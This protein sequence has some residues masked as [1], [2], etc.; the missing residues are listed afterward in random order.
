M[1]TIR[2]EAARKFAVAVVQRLR[3]AGFQ[4]LWAGG[5]VRDQ[6]LGHRPKDYDVATDARPDQVRELFGRRKTLPIGAA[7]GVISVM[8]PRDAGH[9]EVATFRRD[10]AYSDG[11]HPDS[12]SFST[13][14]EDAQRRD[15]TINGLFYD[16]L[17]Q[18]VIDYVGGQEDLKRRIVRA[19]G[20]PRQRFAEDKLRML[21]AVR[22]TATF[23][24]DLDQAT[25]VAIREQADDLVIVSAERIAAEMRRMLS[26]SNRALAVWLLDQANLLT[27]VLPEAVALEPDDSDPLTGPIDRPWPRTLQ[28]LAALK[29]HDFTAAL[30]LLLRE[31][32]PAH[33]D[34]PEF[35]ATK[36]DE[37]ALAVVTAVS[38]RWRLSNEERMGAMRLVADEM[39]LR[40]ALHVAWPR[41]QRL[42][43]TPDIERR[44]AYTEAIVSVL[45]GNTKAVEYCR[46]R[47]QRPSEQLNPPPLVSGNDL[48]TAGLKPGPAFKELLDSIRDAQLEGRISTKAEAL[49]LARSL[50][51]PK[52]ENV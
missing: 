12:V 37:A 31:M 24:F 36:V 32:R 41:L 46:E 15:F 45:D 43:I 51:R 6:L 20:E 5:C 17:E 7:F 10:A 13:P 21:R 9:I 14:E 33:P 30:A 35:A 16:P 26:H 42:L 52:G 39:V 38:D 25:L 2:P 18:R 49:E 28:I 11:R 3:E 1:S 23:G 27:I 8:G 47:L 44:L 50:L 40:N 48:K 29:P 34:A 22:F 19:I 4:A